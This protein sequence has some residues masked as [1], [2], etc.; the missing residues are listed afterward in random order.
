MSVLHNPITA[1]RADVDALRAVSVLAVF[2]F[3]LDISL[4]SGGFVG[5]DV[6]YVI[7]GY[8]IFRIVLQDIAERRFSLSAFWRRRVCRIVPALLLTIVACT[9]MGWWLMTP[10]EYA[11]FGYSALAALFSVSNFYFD[12]RLSYFGDNARDVPLVHTWSLGVEE[13]FYLLAPLLVLWLVRRRSVDRLPLALA[14]V[15]NHACRCAGAHGAPIADGW[16]KC[17]DRRAGSGDWLF[18]PCDDGTGSTFGPCGADEQPGIV[19]RTAGVGLASA[20]PAGG[21]AWGVCGLPAR[22]AVRRRR[23]PGL[24]WICTAVQG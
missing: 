22:V 20:R 8:V 23:V 10:A 1:Y 5:V 11:E 13:Q 18:S 7:S 4:F 16:C 17:R 12:D 2:L 24:R 21:I 14:T 6:F 15:A 9:A 3:H 19:R